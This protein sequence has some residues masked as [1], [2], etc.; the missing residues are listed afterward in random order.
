MAS[1]IQWYLD[2]RIV[3]NR[4]SGS[5]SIETIMK[6]VEVM[7]DMLAE[8]EAPIHIIFDAR[9]LKAQPT[10]IKQLSD[11]SGRIMGHEALGTVIVVTE[12]PM[13]RF[14][15]N[16]IVQV[17]RK[18]I[19]IVASLAEGIETLERL[20]VTLSKVPREVPLRED[21]VLVEVDM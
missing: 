3:Y 16:I 14:V 4:F 8:G 7:L 11:A 12:N 13:Q 21:V 17:F 15:S 18:S 6:G 5:I 19:K 20:D 2:K 1:E 10:N 9:E